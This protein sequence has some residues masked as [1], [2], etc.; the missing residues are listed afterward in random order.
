MEK[1]KSKSK[2]RIAIFITTGIIVVSGAVLLFMLLGDKEEEW[3]KVLSC[4]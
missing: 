1:D 4:P 2:G 3:E